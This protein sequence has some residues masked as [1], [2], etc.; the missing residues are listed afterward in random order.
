[1]SGSSA[2]GRPEVFLHIGTF[3]A[4]TSYI[5]GRLGDNVEQLREDG[6]LFPG[7]AGYASQVSAVRDL[8][9][10]E[11][12]AAGRA[13]VSWSELCDE[14]L[15]WRG[16]AAIVSMEFLS[17]A[18][19]RAV[20]TA[21]DNLL[22]AN[23]KIIVTARDLVRVIPS[24]WQESTQNG[25]TRTWSEFIDSVTSDETSGR[26][27]RYWST[28]DAS[29]VVTRWL[30]AVG[31]ESVYVITVPPSGAPPE[32]LWE[33]F[34][35]VVGFEPE[36]Y[37]INPHTG[38]TNSSLDTASAE[39]LRRVNQA[40][41]KDFPKATYG[42]YV[43][44]FLAKQALVK[45]TTGRKPVLP[46]QYVDWAVE[47]SARIAEAIAEA[48]VHVVG[49]LD[50]LVP[51]PS[52][53]VTSAIPDDVTDTEVADAAIDAIV[54]LLG[55]LAREGRRP[56]ARQGRREVEQPA[57]GGARAARKRRPGRGT[58]ERVS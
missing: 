6:I 14:I 38:R 47:R 40:L 29:A 52:K 26:S 44:Q 51:K 2:T 20:V 57:G 25:Q 46:A 4:G 17:A 3:K 49:D 36:R 58:A 19:R 43:K 34:A 39:L 56:R 10:W 7:R 9:Q 45:R 42:T 22:P 35:Y 23:V 15:A 53:S 48:G 50:E 54:G 37:P 33:R 21:V 55:E 11:Q 28:H 12:T 30:D 1:M 32:V 31:P 5:Q 8:L 13:R 16:H 24:S 41:P 18:N 27:A